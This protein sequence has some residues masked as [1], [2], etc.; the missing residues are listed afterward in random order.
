MADVP[1]LC[2]FTRATTLVDTAPYNEIPNYLKS[3]RADA[4]TVYRTLSYIDALHF[5]P[6]ITARTLLSVALMDNICPPSTI[7]ATYNRIK[8]K[9][10][11]RI[12]P[13]NTHEGGANVQATER[14]R[15]AHRHL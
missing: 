8:A 9:K 3:R 1:F 10:E 5:A 13:F 2:H 11:I 4:A 6:R 7:F 12:Y 14:L 15:F